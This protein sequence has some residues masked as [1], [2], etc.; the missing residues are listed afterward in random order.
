MEIIIDELNAKFTIDG[1]EYYCSTYY[2]NGNLMNV[3]FFQEK[4]SKFVELYPNSV[5]QYLGKKLISAINQVDKLNLLGET[6]EDKLVEKIKALDRLVDLTMGSMPNDKILPIYSG[7]FAG[8]HYVISKT[9]KTKVKDLFHIYRDKEGMID[10]SI[11]DSK[12]AEYA[13]INYLQE[14]EIRKVDF[15]KV[16]P[17]TFIGFVPMGV[18]KRNL[19]S[20]GIFELTEQGIKCKKAYG[21][22]RESATIYVLDFEEY[23]EDVHSALAKDIQLITTLILKN[24]A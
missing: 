13:C 24:I 19:Y 7:K 11:M 2:L 4:Q 18:K 3:R 17:I 8:K 23:T 16:S 12:L 5:D 15:I 22:K 6:E 20:I 1:E 21:L 14:K 9:K 10:V